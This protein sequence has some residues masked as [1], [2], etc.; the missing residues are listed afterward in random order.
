MKTKESVIRTLF[1]VNLWC[2]LSFRDE[3]I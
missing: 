3:K 2:L 1:T